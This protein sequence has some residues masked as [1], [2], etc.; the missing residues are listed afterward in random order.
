MLGR[1]SI[2]VGT[3]PACPYAAGAWLTGESGVEERPRHQENMKDLKRG[4]KIMPIVYINATYMYDIVRHLP[5]TDTIMYQLV[6][7]DDVVYIRKI[8]VEKFLDSLVI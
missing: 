8:W 6:T 7:S 2:I 4:M 5:E 3:C 1:F